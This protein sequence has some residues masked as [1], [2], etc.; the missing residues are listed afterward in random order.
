MCV[1]D[2]WPSAKRNH[3]AALVEVL[4][5]R[6]LQ[7]HVE[8]EKNQNQNRFFFFFLRRIS[9]DVQVGLLLGQLWRELR[10]EHVSMCW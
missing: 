4:D 6:I 10:Q 5:I 1:I 7:G 2:D 8:M 3:H 9:S